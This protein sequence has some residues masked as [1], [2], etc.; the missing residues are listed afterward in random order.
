PPTREELERRRREEEERLRRLEQE[1]LD[2]LIPRPPEVTLVY[3]GSFGPNQRRV[4]VFADA[5]RDK[6]YNALAGDVLEGKFIVD[7]IGYESVDVKFV[8]FPEAPAKRLAI[9]G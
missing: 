4:A 9:G 3:L 2:R 7:R 8:G 6:I 5:G 1:R